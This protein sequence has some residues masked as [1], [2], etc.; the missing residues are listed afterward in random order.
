MAETTYYAVLVHAFSSA[1][2]K[3]STVFEGDIGS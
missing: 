3:R 1:L 2:T